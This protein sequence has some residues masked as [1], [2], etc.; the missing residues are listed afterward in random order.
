MKRLRL[1]ASLGARL[2]L[3]AAAAVAVAVALASVTSYFAVRAKLRGQVDQSLETR[4]NVAD[5]T[6]RF[7][8]RLPP[9]ALGTALP[10]PAFGGANTYGQLISPNGEL[11]GHPELAPALPPS[12]RARA[13]AAGTS[14]P[15]LADQ[16][17]AG[18][19][20]RVLT[21]P[22]VPGAAVQIALPLT[23]ADHTLSSLRIL[24]AL[25]TGAGVLLAALLG[26]FV[27]RTAL[28]PV[29]AFTESTEL[30]TGEPLGRR[31][32]VERDD[33]LGRL[34]RSF[35]T[36]LDAL[37][38]SVE[39]QRQLVADA[40]HELR[41]PIAS[42]R[43]NIQVLAR[44]NDMPAGE[45]EQLM[46]DVVLE[47]DELTALVGD[48]VDLARGA[49]PDTLSQELR[50]DE[51]AAACVEKAERRAPVTEFVERLQPCVVRGDPDR[52]GRAIDNLLSNAVKWNS[53]GQPVEVTLVNGRLIVRDHGPGFADGDLPR[54]FDRFYRA[55]EAR[56]LPG[57][58]LG[59]AIV[60]QV[61]DAH[62]ATVSAR[63]AEGGGACLELAFP[64]ARV[65]LPAAAEA[66][67][68]PAEASGVSSP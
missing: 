6:G 55:A 66:G 12:V 57:S 51:L 10:A 65:S 52:L 27:S 18:V 23:D 37:E 1:P 43:T 28:R 22:V 4:A 54:V 29:R 21:E 30:V 26:W 39:S 62:G 25:I 48:V 42:L 41:T 11:A 60:R 58:G 3:A 46:R 59:L 35:N 63:N 5:R 47:L 64:A 2:S 45:R 50:L 38:S 53:P 8:F 40:S 36:T 31:L 24:L 14:G 17:V 32:S 13:V 33:E 16:T 34:A 15:F 20:L 61:A 9:G 56:G 19:H 67:V 68:L 44:A 49:Q 7:L